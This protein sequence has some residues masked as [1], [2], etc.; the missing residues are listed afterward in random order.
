MMIYRDYGN[1]TSQWY[2]DVGTMHWSGRHKLLF[3]E[4]PLIRI[5]L[6]H[7]YFKYIYIYI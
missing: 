5:N 1:E 3:Y 7:D 2:V 4:I 6:T